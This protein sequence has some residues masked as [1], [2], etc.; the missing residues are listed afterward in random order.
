MLSAPDL[1]PFS[2]NCIWEATLLNSLKSTL[3]ARLGGMTII[4]M[5]L[6]AGPALA[7]GSWFKIAGGWSGMAMDDVNN[8][9]FAFYETTDGFDFPD[10]KSGFSL[11]FHAGFDVNR[12]FGLGFS[13]DHQYAKV[14]GNDQDI[15]GHLNLGANLFMGHGYWT[16][17]RNE[18]IALGA[19]GG[20]GPILAHGETRVQQGSI[21]YG[22]S[23]IRGSDWAFE[24]MGVFD[25]RIKPG[26]VLQLTAGWRWAVIDDV[27]LDTAPV[28]KD[29]GERLEL[30]YT[31]YIVKLGVKWQLGWDGNLKN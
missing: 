15:E 6:A 14:N 12:R 29:N 1:F 17:V 24:V 25:Y 3:W 7:E 28:Y 22:Q 5:L 18:K 13:W 20:L 8:G 30:D 19:A 16:P 21:D 4:L 2:K 9:D 23:R 31:G 11:S 10:L 26:T 27:K